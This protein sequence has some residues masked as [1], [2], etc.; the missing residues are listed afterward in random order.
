[1]KLETIIEENV[2]VMKLQVQ[3]WRRPMDSTVEYIRLE[4]F[5]AT[6][7]NSVVLQEQI[8]RLL[9]PVEQ[10]PADLYP[11]IGGTTANGWRQIGG[12]SST[13]IIKFTRDPLDLLCIS[14]GRGG[15]VMNQDSSVSNENGVE[16]YTYHLEVEDD[17]GQMVVREFR[18]TGWRSCQGL[19]C[20]STSSYASG[21]YEGHIRILH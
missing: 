13:Y 2:P 17:N 15:S 19:R 12:R 21:P 5:F 10:L 20:D 4:D 18:S 8:A 1:M 3:D 9:P 14:T 11:N 6:H 7:R 16:G